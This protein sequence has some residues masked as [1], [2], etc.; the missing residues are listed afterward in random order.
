[1]QLELFDSP[2]TPKRLETHIERCNNILTIPEGVQ[3]TPCTHG[4][5]RFPGKF[6][7]NIPR[8]IIR[9]LLPQNEKRIIFDPFCGSGTTLVEAALEGRPFIGMDIDPLAVALATVKSQPLSKQEQYTLEMFWKEH[10]YQEKHQEVIPSVPNLSHW[11]T[12]KTIV[13]LSSLKMRCYEL[14]PKLR[15]FSLLVFSSII[16]RVSNADD[17]TQK[18]YVSHTLP[19]HP[20]TPSFLFPLFL[21]RALQGMNEYTQLLLKEPHGKVHLGDARANMEQLQFDDIITSPP[22]IDSIDYVYNQMLEYFWLLS[23]L[24]IA[25]F[26]SLR[27]LRKEPMGFRES[28]TDTLFLNKY[29]THHT[30]AFEETCS[31]IREKSQKEEL[32]VRSFFHDYIQ[33]IHV[34]RKVQPRGGRYVC[35]VG[36]SSIRGTI[37]H[38]ADFLVAIHE[39][40]GYRLI[41]TLSYEIKRHYMKFPRRSNSGTIRQDH[42]L[43]FEAE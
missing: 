19:K 34:V 28:L 1:M 6:I 36:N 3:T 39:A 40:S 37:V 41:D 42:V 35:I 25:S 30:E 26:E 29:L 10:N 24:G 32:A 8:Y 22:Y 4:L 38:T 12:E 18:T 20:P 11:F 7:P 17:Q 13:E 15:L 2:S 33:H 14:P 23:D 31:L 43:I 16:R 21:K 5:H 27:Q 9:T